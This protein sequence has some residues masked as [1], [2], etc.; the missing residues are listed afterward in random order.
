M[1]VLGSFGTVT[2]CTVIL[3]APRAIHTTGAESTFAIRKSWVQILT[4]PSIYSLSELFYFSIN[5]NVLPCETGRSSV[6][7][8]V[9]VRSHSDK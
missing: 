1:A 7:Q 8:R 6:P 5:L 3:R 2:A 9:V 4:S